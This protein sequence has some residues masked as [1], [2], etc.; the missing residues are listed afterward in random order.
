MLEA[1]EVTAGYGRRA[2]LHGVTL[3]LHPGEFVG[4]IGPNGGGK[5]TLLRALSGVL[6]PTGGQVLL[7][8]RDLRDL[9]ANARAQQIG[10]VPQSENAAFD[11][12]VREV[13]LMGRHPHH[14]GLGGATTQ[15]Y[16]SVN[17][18]LA[19]TD[20]LHLA[21]RP[22]TQLSG[23]EHRRVLL[24]RA[25][26]QASRLLLLDEPTAHLDISH[27]AELME[28]IQRRAWKPG[29]EVGALAALHDLNQA[30]EFCDR[31]ILLC[32]GRVLAQGKPEAVLT[33]ANLGRAYGARVQVGRNPATGRPLIL[34]LAPA[35]Y[36]SVLP[37]TRHIH[38]ICGGGSGVALMGRLVRAGFVV[39][40]GVLNRLDS[41]QEA[42]AALGIEAALEAP[43]SPFTPA[44]C[45][46]AR[47]LIARAETL[48]IAP[49][50]FGH[51]NLPNLE[52]AARAQA[53][54]KV[55]VLLGD[56]RFAERDYAAGQAGRL[57]KQ[58][59]AGGAQRFERV[60]E[61]PEF[62][63]SNAASDP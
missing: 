57:F 14:A 24:A 15:D 34:T 58:I 23:G 35:H 30:A 25:L 39:T 43:Y 7:D 1:R 31:L 44:A 28:L 47:E 50:P 20:V 11:F 49:V 45:D 63:K 51:G 33:A 12:T 18:A 53:A 60:E 19:A 48:L 52:L 56:D 59:L 41:D 5:S 2:V 55:I 9:G 13:A 46:K 40:T 26:V 38:L 29:E 62:M 61:W 22:I 6:R 36:R 3:A 54:G 27:Q 42:A 10:F 17:R 16:E 37:E 4:L 21:D 8:G 32:E